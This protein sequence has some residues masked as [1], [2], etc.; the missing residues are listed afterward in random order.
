MTTIETVTGPIEGEDVGLALPHEHLYADLLG[1]DHPDFC[2]VDWSEVRAACVDRL[3]GLR[4][5]GVDLFVDVTA[6][7]IGRNV[8]LIRDVSEAT[9]V[10][11]AC[12][13]GIYKG[14]VPPEWTGATSEELAEHFVRDLTQG[15]DDTGVKAGVI[16]LATRETQATARETD[17]YR[18]GAMASVAAGAAVVLH[19]PR[20]DL[21][22]AVLAV[23][24][25]EGFD[26]ARLVWA[27]AHD[28]TIEDNLELAARGVTISFDA[29]G[30]SEDTEMLDRVE[31]LT[32]AGHGEQIVVSTDT[33]V[34][35][36]PPEMAYERS[37]E[38][39]LGTFLP[40]VEE[41]L[42]ADTRTRLARENVVRALGLPADHEGTP[43]EG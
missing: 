38:H 1:P 40:A 28:S 23:L 37:I 22:R 12:A 35:I 8:E 41:R 13:T 6:I 29:I 2:K 19:S 3:T 9:G 16:K 42:G 26:P 14:L 18:A 25:A 43:K 17:V 7:G 39:L 24:E 27:H 32:A 15:I 11:I 21:A 5:L 20:S 33:T 30:V 34:W 10:R 36:N 31:R 4:R